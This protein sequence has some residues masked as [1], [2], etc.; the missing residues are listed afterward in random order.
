MQ[1]LEDSP[2]PLDWIVWLAASFGVSEQAAAYRLINFR[3][4]GGANAE[5]VQELAE[6]TEMT[7]E[8]FTPTYQL[9]HR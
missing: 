5:A 8:A 2:D 7:R 4:V 1:R 9:G 6:N 3:L